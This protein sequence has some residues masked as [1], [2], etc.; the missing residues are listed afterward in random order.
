M[1]RAAIDRQILWD[2]LI[3]V[4]EEQAHTMIRAAFSPPVREGG[5]LSAGLFD[6]HGR[7]LAQAVTGTPGHINTMAS[8]VAHFLDVFPTTGMRPGDAYVT[9]DPWLASGHL[10]DVTVVTPAFLAGRIVGLFAATVHLVDV[11]G[12]GM[13]TDGREIFEEGISIPHIPLARAGALNEDLLSIVRA[14]SREPLQVEGDLLAILAAGEEGAR[15]LAHVLQEFGEDDVEPIGNY[16][17]DTSQ[18]ATEQAIGRLKPGTYRNRM[19]IDGYDRPVDLVVAMTVGDG[20]IALDFEGTSPRSEY[21]INVVLAYTA[22]YSCYGLKCV[23]APE[24][25]NNWGSLAPFSVAAPEGSILNPQRPAPVSA[26]HIIGHALPD[27]VMGCLDQALPGEAV[28]ESGMMWNPYLR[29][30]EGFAGEPRLWELFCFM[31]GGMGARAGKD[32]LSAT[33]FPAGIKNIPV[34]AIEAVAPMVFWRKELRPDSGGAGRQRGGLGQVVE[35]AGLDGAALRFQAMFDRVV[36][37]ARGRAGGRSGAAGKVSLASGLILR[38]KGQQDIPQGDRL[39]LELPGGGGYG[40]PAER[41]PEAVER[42]LAEEFVSPEAAAGDY[43]EAA[44]I[45]DASAELRQSSMIEPPAAR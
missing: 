38:S 2:R 13:G 1:R 35:I 5:D 45:V 27:A 20:R 43:G 8:A 9:N 24:V 23:V 14:N 41:D 36:H 44:V 17:L 12:R 18:R 15:R 19:T 34:E 25:P 22:A 33:A 26:R 7:M 32:G 39:V 3:A 29:G 11:G 21:G 6:L 40:D 31:S 37:P 30:T 42:D 28:A 16:I 4:A 10:H